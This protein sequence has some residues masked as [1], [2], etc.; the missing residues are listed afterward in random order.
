MAERKPGS[1]HGRPLI[2]WE[3]AFLFYAGLPPERR[4]YQLVADEFGVSV[5][6]VERHGRSE[7]WKERARELDR[8][9]AAAA[10]EQL[11]DQRTEKLL[12][13]EKLIDASYL[14]YATQLRDGTVRVSPADLPRLHK[15]RTDLWTEAN[16]PAVEPVEPG[17]VESID[18]AEHRLQVL[19]ALDAAGVLE[20][21]L[22]RDHDDEQAK[23][24]QDDDRHD[25]D[26]RPEQEEVSD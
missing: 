17:M 19:R 7:R 4:G 16:N 9:A 24:A 2:D 20:H 12:D 13:V 6:T 15:L 5:R 14:T 25:D 1:D 21:L 26:D 23:G 11:R 3:Q 18:P 22:H 8:S 10:A